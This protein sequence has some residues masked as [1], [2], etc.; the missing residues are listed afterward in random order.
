[1]LSQARTQ[2]QAVVPITLSWVSRGTTDSCSPQGKHEKHPDEMRKPPCDYRA[3]EGTTDVSF[4]RCCEID[5]HNRT[6]M[7]C[8]IVPDPTGH[9]RA[10]SPALVPALTRVPPLSTGFPLVCSTMFMDCSHE[11]HRR[12]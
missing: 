1:M 2:V 5:I 7:A 6:V 12:L 3:R 11:N 4:E 10:Q 8:L 9:I